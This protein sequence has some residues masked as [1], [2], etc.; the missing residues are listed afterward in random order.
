MTDMDAVRK[1]HLRY[2]SNEAVDLLE[3]D[4]TMRLVLDQC[5]ADENISKMMY[6]NLDANGE[7]EEEYVWGS[8]LETHEVMMQYFGYTPDAAWPLI[9]EF[10]KRFC[11]PVY[12]AKHGLS[13]CFD[14]IY[15]YPDDWHA[16]ATEFFVTLD[17]LF[18]KAGVRFLDW[19][20]DVRMAYQKER[21]WRP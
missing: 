16:M 13:F 20:A 17:G 12:C 4:A 15:W 2:M 18:T 9:M 14:E 1:E 3:D 11:D 10:H 6:L 5:Y 21:P 7:V 19:G 8:L